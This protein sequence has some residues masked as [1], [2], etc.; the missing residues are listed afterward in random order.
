VLI[1][2]SPQAL[3]TW[4]SWQNSDRRERE[5]MP[6]V[7]ATPLNCITRK[8]KLPV[9]IKLRKQDPS[10]DS[11]KYSRVSCEKLH[12]IVITTEAIEKTI[13]IP[14]IEPVYISP[15]EWRR[16]GKAAG[17]EVSINMGQFRQ[18]LEER[19]FISSYYVPRNEQIGTIPATSAQLR[20]GDE[21]ATLTLTFDNAGT[22]RVQFESR[23]SRKMFVLEIDLKDDWVPSIE[24]LQ[25]FGPQA[26]VE[27]F[28][29]DRKKDKKKKDKI[30]KGFPISIKNDHSRL[31]V[32]DEKVTFLIS[33]WL[34]KRAENGRLVYV[35]A[36]NIDTDSRL[37][38]WDENP[39]VPSMPS[40]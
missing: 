24:L 19:F 6:I 10:G 18:Y 15:E 3:R 40:P 36:V 8:T 30:K 2:E 14:Q 21:T 11:Q 4:R 39:M 34:R 25:C 29:I 5:Y 28:M 35:I 37:E 22:Y 17:L 16:R 23:K 9:V 33:M 27:K 1:S 38:W 26:E 20:E 13:F 12:E 31:L 32:V 7:Y